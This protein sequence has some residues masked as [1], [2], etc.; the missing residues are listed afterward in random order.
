MV[1]THAGN[2]MKLLPKYKKSFSPNPNENEVDLDETDIQL[3]LIVPL[4]FKGCQA[5][6]SI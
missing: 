6:F 2:C 3:F 4:G 1:T 5:F